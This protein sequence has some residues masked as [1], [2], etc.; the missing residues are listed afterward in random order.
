M[1]PSAFPVQLSRFVRVIS[2]DSNRKLSFVRL[3]I[4]VPALDSHTPLHGQAVPVRHRPSWRPSPFCSIHR[5]SE[6]AQG[7]TG[8]NDKLGIVFLSALHDDLA[9][10]H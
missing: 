1:A 5:E 6:V 2:H 4:P 8:Q 9:M 3:A 10:K 7:G